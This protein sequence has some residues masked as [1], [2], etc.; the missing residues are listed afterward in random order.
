[1]H[2]HVIACYYIS[3]SPTYS[4]NVENA[5][6][7]LTSQYDNIV[8]N[9][10]TN[11]IICVR[12]ASI[13]CNQHSFMLCNCKPHYQVLTHE[14]GHVFGLKHCYYFSCA[15]NESTSIFQAAAQPLF[16]CPICLRK[17]HKVLKFDLLERYQMLADQCLNLAVVTVTPLDSPGTERADQDINKGKQDSTIC[18]TNDDPGETNI[19]SGVKDDDITV[20]AQ[21]VDSVFI[22]SNTDQVKP[23]PSAS[24]NSS[25]TP[26]T[27]SSRKLSRLQTLSSVSSETFLQSPSKYFEDA[28]KWFERASLCLREYQSMH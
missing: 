23:S 5:L 15:M 3:P 10:T 26:P 22:D 13:L 17:L 19:S 24:R 28:H 18:E 11:Y 16:L 4:I 20:L 27:T 7:I 8:H 6:A 25:L 12:H 2:G 21:T 1:M 9:I 14:M